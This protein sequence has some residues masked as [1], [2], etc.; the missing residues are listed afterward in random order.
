MPAHAAAALAVRLHALIAAHEEE[1]GTAWSEQDDLYG[2][3]CDRCTGLGA[4][5]ELLGE[6]GLRMYKL[7]KNLPLNGY[8]RSFKMQP[9]RLLT[10]R[11]LLGIRRDLLIPAQLGEILA[12]LDLP[13]VFR[14]A[15]LAGLPHTSFLHF[16]HEAGPDGV[17][18]KLYQEFTQD[19]KAPE[20]LLF[21]GYKWDPA[22]PGRQ[23]LTRYRPQSGMNLDAILASIATLLE[24]HAEMAAV[25]GMIVS[26]A[27]TR[28]T[29]SDLC[30]VEVSEDGNAR[31]SCD[32]NLYA[33]ELRL[34]D[35][36]PLV[37]AAARL[38]GIGEEKVDGYLAGRR[39]ALLGHVSCG[40]GRDGAP[41]LTVYY[42]LSDG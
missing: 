12:H 32:I 27:A 33:A 1:H 13:E 21:A 17:V 8:E 10:E 29:A 2:D 20:G 5:E 38:S 4:G 37:R 34:A 42:K 40:V 31:L 7:L 36:M 22:R 6:H 28:C 15:F 3:L 25:T 23:V 11:Y 41:F 39:E 26:H 24:G 14:G 16:G 19:G 30:Y 18:R 35:V 9:G